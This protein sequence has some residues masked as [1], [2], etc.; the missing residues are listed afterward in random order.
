MGNSSEPGLTRQG[1]EVVSHLNGVK[2]LSVIEDHCM[3]DTKAGDDVLSGELSDFSDGDGSHVS[4]Y[5]VK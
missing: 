2:F 1:A 5:F 4:I 3:G